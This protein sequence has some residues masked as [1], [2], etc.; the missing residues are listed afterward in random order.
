MNWERS[1]LARRR[2]PG[3]TRK[4]PDLIPIN[5]DLHLYPKTF[6][7]LKA[8]LMILANLNQSIKNTDKDRD[9]PLLRFKSL[10]SSVLGALYANLFDMAKYAL[11]EIEE[12]LKRDLPQDVDFLGYR[13]MK[14]LT[15]LLRVKSLLSVTT[16]TE[17]KIRPSQTHQKV[18][19]VEYCMCRLCENYFPVD[20]I[21]QHMLVCAQA[22]QSKNYVVSLDEKIRSLIYT[23]RTS[24]LDVNW[25]GDQTNAVG[26]IFPVLHCTILLE[27]LLEHDAENNYEVDS[28]Q[29]IYDGLDA[30]RIS[31]PN[32]ENARNILVRAVMYCREKLKACNT[33]KSAYISEGSAPKLVNISDFSFKKQISRGAYARVFLAKKESTGDVVAIKVIS[34]KH[35]ARKNT[36]F[37]EKNI[38]VKFQSEHVVSLYYTLCGVNNLYIVMEYVPGG[39]LKTVLHHLGCMDEHNARY[40]IVQ[41]VAALQDLRKHKIVHRDLKPDNILIDRDGHL[42]LADFGLSFVGVVEKT[43]EFAGTPDYV[44]PEIVLNKGHSFPADYWSLGVII[45]ELLTGVP[46]FHGKTPE[47]TFMNI[48]EGIFEPIDGSKEA[49]DLIRQLLRP[50]PNERLG[51]R[52]VSDIMEHPFFKG[53]DWTALDTFEPPFCP[54]LKSEEDTSYF[55]NCSLKDYADIQF[56]LESNRKRSFSFGPEIVEHF[57]SDF[58][59]LNEMIKNG[60]QIEDNDLSQFPVTSMNGLMDRTTRT[61]SHRRAKHMSFETALST[62][63]TLTTGSLPTTAM[64]ST[65]MIRPM[66]V[67]K[68]RFSSSKTPEP[69]QVKQPISL[70]AQ[71]NML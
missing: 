51:C 11:S 28:L 62:P 20:Q 12:I 29:Y 4:I 59:K 37:T 27:R 22:F 21:E 70:V 47:E 46:P 41:I 45:Y 5:P 40:Y 54:C 3:N 67:K 71:P 42:K 26:L 10:I 7:Y 9:S 60:Q 25:P 64:M 65:P 14:A 15:A 34:R 48:C 55:G 32:N 8:Q 19:N 68:R 18:E 17:K 44:A 24:I 16:A 57:K 66:V 61:A 56:D 6:A 1:S 53:I 52:S 33:L 39:D 2:S 36:A 13:I 23:A 43:L 38:L 31:D 63:I 50:N 30:L 69:I 35:A 58:D 49:I